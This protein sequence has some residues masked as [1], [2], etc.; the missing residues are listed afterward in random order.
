[1]RVTK[2]ALILPVLAACQQQS[3]PTGNVGGLDL[4]PAIAAAASQ[5]YAC[6]RGQTIAVTYEAGSTARINV[7]G[8]TL[9]MTGKPAGRGVLYTAGAS[10]W[11]VVTEGNRET[12]ELVREDGNIIV[13][14]RLT[15]AA[16][17]APTLTSCRADQLEAELGETDAGMGHRHQL[18]TLTVKGATGCL[19]PKWPQL[20]PLQDKTSALTVEQTTDS[21]FVSEEGSDRVELKS[22]DKAQFYL[23][24]S[25]IPNEAAGEKVC[26]KVRGWNIVAPGGGGLP[27]LPVDIEACG[28]KVTVSPFT[29]LTEQENTQPNTP[30]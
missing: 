19:L 23:G 30:R 12:G 22:G 7:D 21:Y 14:S 10:R 3:A 20:T 11:H 2:L 15:N 8:Q 25:V 28:G 6:G 16:A 26:P 27:T 4:E 13:C 9:T 17:P 18:V 1:M 24:W 5:E 29:K